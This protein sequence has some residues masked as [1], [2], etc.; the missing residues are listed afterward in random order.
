MSTDGEKTIDDLMKAIFEKYGYYNG[1]CNDE[2]FKQELSELT[3]H[4]FTQFFYH[5]VY[6]I[7]ELPLDWAFEDDD[8][9]GLSNFTEISWD[10]HPEIID[11]DGDGFTDFDEAKQKTDPNSSMSYPLP[12]QTPSLTPTVTDTPTSIPTLTKAPI[13]PDNTSRFD[14]IKQF[15]MVV[16]IIVIFFVIAM[17]IIAMVVVRSQK[18]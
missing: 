11:T 3:G 12:T 18:R 9:D 14:E 7:V 4:D 10:T 16:A 15:D 1:S 13:A 5:Y 6:G 2:C 17:V 8:S